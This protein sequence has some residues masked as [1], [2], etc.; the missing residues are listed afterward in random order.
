MRTRGGSAGATN[1]IS[2]AFAVAARFPVRGIM[3][4]AAIKTRCIAN[5]VTAAAYR[6]VRGRI[7]SFMD[8]SAPT[9]PKR[10]TLSMSD[11]SGPQPTIALLK[12]NPGR[13]IFI[14]VILAAAVRTK[15]FAA[16]IR[17]DR[18]IGMPGTH[19]ADFRSRCAA[20]ATRHRPVYAT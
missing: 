20:I 11:G 13:V 9:G 2:T 17:K 1:T 8:S 15:D 18:E 7:D 19:L 6:A 4:R 10:G 3:M 14:A 12:Q 16:L 5:T